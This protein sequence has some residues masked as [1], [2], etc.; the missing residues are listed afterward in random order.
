MERISEPPRQGG[1]TLLEVLVAFSILALSL[2]ILLRIFGGGGRLA[3]LA[4]EH[5]RAVIL[6]ES[7]LA[8][9]GVETALRPGESSG[10]ID[11]RY[12]RTLRVAPYV[13]AGEPLPEPLEFKPY[14]VELNVVWG[15]D[16]G[17][18]EFTLGTLRLLPENREPGFRR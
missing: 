13:V 2:G 3:G 4:D 5:A 6:A 8:S 15:E 12:R 17:P 1:F 9:A 10:E 11:N 16:E 18:H 7:L 14:W